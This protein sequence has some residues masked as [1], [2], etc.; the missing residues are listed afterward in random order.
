MWPNSSTATTNAGVAYTANPALTPASGNS[1][2]K[3]SFTWY[4]AGDSFGSPS[5]QP[6]YGACGQIVN[7]GYT[8]AVSQNLYGVGPGAGAGPACNTCYSISG[9]TDSSGNILP[10]GGTTIVV[11]INNLCPAEGNPMCSQPDLWSSNQYGAQVNFD[12]CGDS[13]AAEGFFPPGTGIV[14]GTVQLLADCSS[15]VGS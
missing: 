14:L 2:Y 6:I 3:A 1:N 13:G 5:C 12:L 7:S 15:W 4:G 9:Q 11:K 8:A 10:G